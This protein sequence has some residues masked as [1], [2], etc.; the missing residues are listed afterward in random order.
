MVSA[1]RLSMVTE[2]PPHIRSAQSGDLDAVVDILADA[3]RADPVMKWVTP[4]PAYPK[5]A[6]GLTVPFCLE[7]GLTYIAEDGS[8]AA[9]WL[10]PGMHLQSPVSPSVIWHGLTEY[11]PMSLL[12]GLATLIQTQKRHPKD[13]YYYL[14]TIGTRPTEQGRG[15]GGAL[16]RAVLQRCDAER[17]PAYLESSNEK[18]L[19]FYRAHGFEVVEEMRLA[20]GGPPM[21]L[22]WRA[23]RID[24]GS[25][26]APP[27]PQA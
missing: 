23:P 1:L 18:N 15:V 16:M 7:K 19:P 26:N 21:W 24:N 25:G 14:F 9:S 2:E 12:R 6:F 10:P 11:G 13:R 22:M 3:F 20:L 27:R 17:M 8:G 4:K 5:Y